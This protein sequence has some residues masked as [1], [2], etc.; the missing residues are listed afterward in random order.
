VIS[1][2]IISAGKLYVESGDFFGTGKLHP[3][4]HSKFLV[5]HKWHIE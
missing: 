2:W 1:D 3:N 4:T 5:N